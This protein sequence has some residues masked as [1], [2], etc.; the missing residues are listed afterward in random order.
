MTSQKFNVANGH[1]VVTACPLYLSV[2]LLL[3]S[4]RLPTAATIRPTVTYLKI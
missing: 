1:L 2:T 3:Y 4:W